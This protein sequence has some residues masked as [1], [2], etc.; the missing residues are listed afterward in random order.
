MKPSLA[1]AERSLQGNWLNCTPNRGPLSRPVV[2]G[3]GGKCSCTIMLAVRDE[4]AF[5]PLD[6]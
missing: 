2:V 6:R 4:K 3:A 1:R 5:P